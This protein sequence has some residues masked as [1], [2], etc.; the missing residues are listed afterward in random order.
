MIRTLPRRLAL[1]LSLAVFAAGA[2][3]QTAPGAASPH[4]GLFAHM[5]QKL[6]TDGDG[7]VS[8]AE[9]L[10][11]ATARFK[12]IDTQN[13]GSFDAATLAASP[14]ATERLTQHAERLVQRLDKANNGY[15]T[16]SEVD[17]AAQKRFARLDKNGDGKLTLEEFSAGHG[18]RFGHFHHLANADAATAATAPTA[19]TGTGAGSFAQR[20]FDKLDTNHDGVVTQDEYLAAANARFAALDPQNSGKVTAAEIATSPRAEAHAQRAAAHRVKAMDTNG[21]GVVTLDEYL[22][23]A[24]K[25]FSR[26][27]KNGD[28]FIDADELPAHHWASGGKAVRVDG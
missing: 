3:A 7:R 19:G 28:G 20:A 1:A 12:Q 16:A 15:I 9:W 18:G 13:A 24:K 23:A 21:D 11:A 17:A 6:D 2:G 10:A 4:A 26:M 25:R 5:L 22:A 8:E 27:D 14:A